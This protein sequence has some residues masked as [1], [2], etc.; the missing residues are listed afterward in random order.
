MIG[1]AVKRLTILKGSDMKLPNRYGTVYKLT[2]K[3]RKPWVARKL[4]GKV[5][6]EE[7]K[8][9]KTIYLTIGYYAKREDALQALAAYNANPAT[10]QKAI[11]F[12]EVHDR[13]AEEHY[14]KMKHLNNLKA[15]I[16]V[17]APLW[18]EPFADIKLDTIQSVF[19]TSGKN[20]PTLKHAKSMLSN[21]YDYAV[22]H[23]IVKKEKKDMI[24]YLN[25]GESNPNSIPRNIITEAEMRRMRD[26]DDKY[27]NMMLVLCFTGLRIGELDALQ[28][29]HIDWQRQCLNVVEAKTKAGI[30]EVPIADKL[31]PRL[32]R[33]MADRPNAAVM[34]KK[35]REYG[36][37]RPHD[38][39]HTFCTLLVEKGV[40]QRLID[41]IVG[42]SFGQNITLS[43]YTHITIEA[44]LAAVNLLEIC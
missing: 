20:T 34:R 14:Q 11:T 26:A 41:T 44:K 25:C 3:R 32:K 27:T 1:T 17:L 30:R 22:V 10:P 29:R 21:L 33:Y 18:Y 7:N 38:A 42:H 24:P 15:S 37:H 23:E 28:E 35:M 40:D 13:W 4:V 8:K 12:K 19:N 2:G 36:E 43:V 9:V 6:D 39:R 16:K 5:L 31:I